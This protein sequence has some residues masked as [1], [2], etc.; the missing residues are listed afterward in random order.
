M[1]PLSSSFADSYLQLAA[2][3]SGSRR[4]TGAEIPM[5]REAYTPS[6]AYEPKAPYPIATSSAHYGKC[7]FFL[8]T[9]RGLL[10]VSILE[11]GSYLIT[12]Q[13]FPSTGPKISLMFIKEKGQKVE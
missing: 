5:R 9:P 6:M 12:L 4:G 1:R 7:V 10:R 8:C 2:S 13:P 3:L 11:P